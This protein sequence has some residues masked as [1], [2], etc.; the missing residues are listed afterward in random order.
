MEKLD[1]TEMLN[2]EECPL[3]TR[4]ER[5]IMD[6]GTQGYVIA[7]VDRKT[8]TVTWARYISLVPERPSADLRPDQPL[9]LQAVR[10]GRRVW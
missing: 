8:R 1:F 3:I 6:H 10:E 9:A 2:E 7:D 4:D 5:R